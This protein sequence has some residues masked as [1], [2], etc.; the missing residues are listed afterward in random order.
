[1][2]YISKEKTAEIRATLKREYPEMR[3]GVRRDNYG[4]LHVSILKSPYEFRNEQQIQAGGS[5]PVNHYYPE[6]FN[7][8]KILSHIIAICNDGN[9]DNSRPEVDYFCVGWYLHITLG[10][11]KTHFQRTYLSASE[12]TKL[13]IENYERW[14][15]YVEYDK[16]SDPTYRRIIGTPANPRWE[17]SL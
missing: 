10:N 3:F 1:M 15:V 13:M 14:K 8:S 6:Q 16:W 9:W 11:W 4:T 2:A 17:V 5:F 7:N 12:Q